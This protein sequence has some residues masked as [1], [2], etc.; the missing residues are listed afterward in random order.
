MRAIAPGFGGYLVIEVPGTG[1]GR[2]SAGV[3]DRSRRK[4][5]VLLRSFTGSG[6]S[7]CRSDVMGGGF[8]TVDITRNDTVVE[9]TF[10]GAVADLGQTGGGEIEGSFRV[11]YTPC[12]W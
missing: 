12:P 5:R 2:W 4:P 6:C 8:V 9:G 11:D 1:V 7:M 3:S 10:S